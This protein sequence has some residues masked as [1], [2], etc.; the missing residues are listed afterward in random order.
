MTNACVW[1]LHVRSCVESTECICT[2]MARTNGSFWCSDAAQLHEDGLESGWTTVCAFLCVCVFSSVSDMGTWSSAVCFLSKRMHSKQVGI[3]A[4]CLRGKIR[5]RARV[6]FFS[7]L[8]NYLDVNTHTHIILN[9]YICIYIC[10]KS[11]CRVGEREWGVYIF[12]FRA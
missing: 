5:G 2:I 9:I 1:F 3:C 4:K 10:E 6:S 11:S 8:C 7:F 12:S